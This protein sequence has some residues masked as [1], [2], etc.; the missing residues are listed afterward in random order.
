MA[1][2]MRLAG[3][4]FG[5]AIMVC[6]GSMLAERLGVPSCALEAQALDAGTHLEERPGELDYC[7]YKLT[8]IWSGCGDYW[9]PESVTT[10]L[11][12][13]DVDLD[14]ID[15]VVFGTDD[16]RV[17]VVDPVVPRI[18]LELTVAEHEVTGIEVG[19]VDEDPGVE[20]VCVAT[21]TTRTLVCVDFASRSVQ[22]SAMGQRALPQLQ[23]SLFD[24]D[25][26]G[27]SDIFVTEGSRYFRVDGH[28]EC[29]YNGSLDLFN[30]TLGLLSSH[31]IEDLDG[32]GA[33]EA[34]FVDKGY[35]WGGAPEWRY[36]GRKLWMVDL[37]TGGVDLARRYPELVF[38]S[39]PMLLRFH[40]RSEVVV[41]LESYYS[42]G[43][44]LFALDLA[45]RAHG[46]RDT[47]DG[48][49]S[50][51]RWNQLSCA[52]GPDGPI[53]LMNSASNARMAWSVASGEGLWS[54]IGESA[55]SH[56]SRTFVCDLDGDGESE[57]VPS[58]GTVALYDATSGALEKDLGIAG[59]VSVGDL[60]GDGRTEMC[61]Y[62]VRDSWGMHYYNVSVIDSPSYIEWEAKPTNGTVTLY[63]DV[64]GVL[65]LMVM[66][67][68][69]AQTPSLMSIVLS[70]PGM[71]DFQ[72]IELDIRN[73]TMAA[74]NDARLEV[75]GFE[76][77]RT[78]S[79][80]FVRLRME[81]GWGFP[82]GGPDEVRLLFDDRRGLPHECSVAD[83]FV[84]ERDLVLVGAL[85]MRLDGAPLAVGSWV[86]PDVDV[87]VTGFDVAYEGAPDLRPARSAFRIIERVG[88]WR[89]ER[90]FDEADRLA[91]QFV[92]PRRN[93]PLAVSLGVNQTLAGIVREQSL[94]TNLRVDGWWPIVIEP[95]G[96]DRWH[97]QIPIEMTVRFDEPDSGMDASCVRYAVTKLRTDNVT[98]WYAP[99][100]D[101][102][103]ATDDPS[104]GRGTHWAKLR[105][106]AP[107]G[108][109]YLRIETTDRVGNRG[110]HWAVVRLD[111]TP[112]TIRAEPLQGWQTTD[113]IE[114][115]VEVTDLDGCGVDPRTVLAS[116]SHEDPPV[117]RNW[118]SMTVEGEGERVTATVV[119]C[120]VEGRSNHFA[121]KAWDMM[122]HEAV[123][124]PS[125]V[126]IDSL[127][128]EARVISPA[129]GEVLEPPFTA[130]MFRVHIIENGSGLGDVVPSVT[131]TSS[132]KGVMTDYDLDR[133]VDGEYTLTVQWTRTSSARYSFS[134]RCTDIVGN[135]GVAGPV[136]IRLHDPP[137]VRICN[138]HD[139][140]VLIAGHECVFKAETQDDGALQLHLPCEWALDGR[141]WV[142]EGEWFSNS[143]I[144]SGT[145][146]VTVRASD[147]VYDVS[148]SITLT[149][150]EPLP[151]PGP[152]SAPPARFVPPRA[153]NAAA[154]VTLLSVLVTI[155]LMRRRRQR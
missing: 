11:S 127:A 131:D 133:S 132:N 12:A 4:L 56:L 91:I 105:L 118:R 104:L 68:T 5:L 119:Y 73:G 116:C 23:L 7:H 153:A 136:T 141:T 114:L 108:L 151:P 83:A 42:S 87:V 143:T 41:G 57:L 97:E 48:D 123:T 34:L 85:Q 96:L 72:S 120:G 95:E 125:T 1:G 51:E 36:V 75:L 128:P 145:Y 14:G 144:P 148:H 113:R 37:E 138:P 146:N 54:A 80:L 71:G 18:L 106:Y 69:K 103:G 121:F 32:D 140:D 63:A 98:R 88:E 27:I 122:G 101:E 115:R 76:R 21:S 81:P 47:S 74:P 19:N 20:L 15:E 124:G 99:Y 67:M 61:V 117:L 22:W 46:L 65:E 45:T 59:G 40:G 6:A 86:A 152:D 58:F 90:A 110:L 64:E 129:D 84:V 2:A 60:D 70:N 29:V 79:A 155:L 53:V 38:S 50:G 28:G 111:R 107:E 55:M 17:V 93:G 137:N 78:E 26:D 77:E 100:A 35:N 139:G 44:D 52:P 102:F 109:G 10:P 43:E 13:E 154:V 24:D 30:E 112:P 16:G 126:R 49:L 66:R 149:V 142:T 39:D 135:V 33:L 130:L 31:I 82:W 134:V 9:S 89:N 147:G 25:D 92:V 62:M 150:V 94:C 3:A 8:E